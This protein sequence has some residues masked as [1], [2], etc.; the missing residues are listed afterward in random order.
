MILIQTL[1]TPPVALVLFGA[2]GDLSQ[3]ML[4]PSLYHLWRDGL[5]SKEMALIGAAR[6]AMDDESFRHFAADSLARF[7]NSEHKDDASVAGFL[8]VLQYCTV[9]VGSTASMAALKSAMP[10]LNDGNAVYYLATAPAIYG[11]I[12]EGLHSVG[13]IGKQSRVV[14]EKPIGKDLASSVIVNQAVGKLFREEQIYRIDHYLGKETV[15]NLLV[16]R[17]GNML[18]EPLWN[19][20]GIEQVQITLSETVGVEGRAAYYD[21]MGAL[22]DMVQNHVLQLLAL[23]AMEPPSE[24]NASAVRN[25]K[26]KVL[27]SLRPITP[28]NIGTHIVAG[29]Y[30]AGAING[31]AVK[32][33]LD[34]EGVAKNSS[35]DSFV[36]I[37]ADIDN[38]RWSGV[39]FYIRTGKRMPSRYSEIVIVFKP[40]PHNIFGKSGGVL[41]PNKLIIRLQP[42][43]VISLMVM[44]KEPGLDREAAQMRE[45]PLDVSLT[46]AFAGP[47]SLQQRRRIAY[48]RLMLDVIDG[49]GTLFVRRD[50]VEAAWSWID[51]I[52]DGWKRTAYK[53]KAYTAGS[54]G[55]SS[56]IALPERFGHRWH[57]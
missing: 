24:M 37:R 42:E 50:E 41:A 43:E 29:Q 39:P 27:R 55:P 2:T 21:T 18:F 46:T 1:A 6:S 52:A 19:N 17:F 26:I 40:V 15:Q 12:A 9:D 49:N 56:A 7:V 51:G 34:E 23:V 11:A 38:W 36:A 35:N 10:V 54:W 20:Q 53:P 25:E 47:T 16:L 57:D 22:R 30:S 14:M 8:A 45:V 3:R 44:A 4:I 32:G 13:L 5:L 33:Y 31:A 48:E 28:E